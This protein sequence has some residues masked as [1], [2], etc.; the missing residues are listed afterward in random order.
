MYAYIQV[1]VKENNISFGILM[2]NWVD[3]ILKCIF[4]ID[5]TNKS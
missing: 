5:S 3:L 2:Y 4:Y 1:W